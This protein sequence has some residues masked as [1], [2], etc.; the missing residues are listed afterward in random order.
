MSFNKLLKRKS[1][2]FVASISNNIG[3]KLGSLFL[4]IILWITITG[5]GIDE[6]KL[7]NVPYQIRN[8]PD[9][10]IVTDKG[11]GVVDLHIRGPRSLLPAI[12]PEDS[13]IVLTLSPDTI[14]GET[15][16]DIA[17][18]NVYL[19]YPNQTSLLQ[20]SPSEVSVTLD[21][22]TSKSVPIRPHLRGNPHP[23]YQ[24]GEWRVD[25]EQAEVQGPKSYLEHLELI[26]T[27]TIDISNQT[28]SFNE[29]V[30]I[31]PASP[32]ISVIRPAR[33]SAR[34][35]IQ[36]RIIERAF[37]DFNVSVLPEETEPGFRVEPETVTLTL[38]GPAALLNRLRPAE[39]QLVADWTEMPPGEHQISPVLVTDHEKLLTIN[40]DP[41]LVTVFIP[42]AEPEQDN[43]DI[44]PPE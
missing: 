11:V 4:A 29:R 33:A 12:R 41:E 7:R 28:M 36:E 24:L 37:T 17:H 5:Q 42:K 20:I 9:G 39:L 18:N 15:K 35:E 34:I 25:P 38:T 6:Q 31:K 16:I 44:I 1:S 27:E 8:V 43:D 23:D 19:P 30:S 40:I 3:L 2:K 13:S 32:L 10:L 21:E 14:I 22:M 26:Y